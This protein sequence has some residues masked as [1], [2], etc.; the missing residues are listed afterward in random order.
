MFESLF[1]VG[2]LN[3]REKVQ[4]VEEEKRAPTRKEATQMLTESI[5]KFKDVVEQATRRDEND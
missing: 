2:L 1:A 5:S 4:P 3:R